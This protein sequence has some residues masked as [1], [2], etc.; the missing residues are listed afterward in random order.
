VTGQTGNS[1]KSE[2]ISDRGADEV[3]VADAEHLLEALGDWRPTVAFDCL[4]G[5]FFGAAIEALEPRGTLVIFGT[6]AEA[7]GEVPL[8]QLYRKGLRVFGY[9]GLIEP[10]HVTLQVIG[11]ALADLAEGRFEVIV[12]SVLPLAEVNTAFERLVDRSVQGKVLLD[13]AR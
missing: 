4:G 9:A 1:S 10:E 8:Q 7:K 11:R 3:V 6:S 12:D 2:W 5:G 13:L